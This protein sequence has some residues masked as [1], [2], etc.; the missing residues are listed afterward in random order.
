[1]VQHNTPFNLCQIQINFV[2]I[3][4][5]ILEEDNTEEYNR[6]DQEE[7]MAD[8]EDIET[9]KE[10]KNSSMSSLISKDASRAQGRLRK[11]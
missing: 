3:V 10:M 11:M 1:M 7:E 6:E 2:R 4:F 9:N 5:R 8:I